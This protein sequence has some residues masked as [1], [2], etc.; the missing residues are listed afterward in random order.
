MN[1]LVV[2]VA[3]LLPL[4]GAI[5]FDWKV[6]DYL[7]MY[8]LENWVVLAIMLAKARIL[9]ARGV[10]WGDSRGYPPAVDLISF[11]A[12]YLLFTVAHG[13]GVFIWLPAVV[14][15]DRSLWGP[16]SVG[17]L[18][19]NRIVATFASEPG[20]LI[21]FLALAASHL[22]VYWRDFVLKRE[23]G[24]LTV[25]AVMKTTMQRV[26]TLHVAV[27]VGGMAAAFLE[28]ETLLP[29]LAILVIL[30]TLLEVGLTTWAFRT[31]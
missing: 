3:N 20:L 1:I 30:K 17:D 10:H 4:L 6:F 28:V 21:G 23:Y 16:L 19:V 15:H 14:L 11:C 18:L 27:L 9:V 7:A 22:F 5:W 13:F 25:H 12:A 8:W 29:V 26:T 24:Y 2:V 31:R